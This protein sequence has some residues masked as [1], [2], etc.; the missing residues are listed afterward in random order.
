MIK[1]RCVI[2][3]IITLSISSCM[4]VQ[5]RAGNKV[6]VTL[7]EN[8]FI[9]G[10]TTPK[11]VLRNLG[12]P[13]GKGKEML[14]IGETVRDVWTYYYEEGSLDDIRRLILYVFFQNNTYDGYLWFSSLL[15]N[16]NSPM[17]SE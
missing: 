7:L 4:N 2:I 11:E 17:T 15:D 6:N 1:I 3:A 13:L 5:I 14:P 16:K 8:Q 10:Q 12:P 9:P